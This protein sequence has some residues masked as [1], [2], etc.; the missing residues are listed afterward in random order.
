MTSTKLMVAHLQDFDKGVIILTHYAF[1][2]YPKIQTP[3]GEHLSKI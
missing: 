3:N 1:N 2:S